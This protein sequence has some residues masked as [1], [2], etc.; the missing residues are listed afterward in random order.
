MRSTI[1]LYC[2]SSPII[3]PPSFTSSAVMPS[4]LPSSFT[5][6][7]NAGGKLCSRPQSRPIFMVYDS[8]LMVARRL[9][10]HFYRGDLLDRKDWSPQHRWRTKVRRYKG[11]FKNQRAGE[12]PAYRQAS[13]RYRIALRT[14]RRAGGGAGG[15]R[16][17]FAGFG[18]DVAH[19]GLQIAGFFVDAQLALGAGAM[20]EDS[21]D[22]LERGAAAEFVQHIVYK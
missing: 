2:A 16:H 11:N 20:A 4:F 12:T 9:Q 5:L 17:A 8:F 18:D 10:S 3:V 14:L 21:T 6:S 1:T 19:D 13:R 22:G 7:T 15:Q